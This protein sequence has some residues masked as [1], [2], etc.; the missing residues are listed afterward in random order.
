M[1]VSLSVIRAGGR[2]GGSERARNGREAPGLFIGEEMA[3]PLPSADVQCTSAA[4]KAT[5]TH[6]T[7]PRVI[8]GPG[9]RW[10]AQFDD[11]A[12]R[13]A[14]LPPCFGRT[15]VAAWA[16]RL[17][18]TAKRNVNNMA[19]CGPRAFGAVRAA[20]SRDWMPR[21]RMVPPSG[22]IGRGRTDGVLCWLFRPGSGV[23]LDWDRPTGATSRLAARAD[24]G[25]RAKPRKTNR[26]RR[27]Q[28]GLA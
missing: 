22:A 17:A 18:E 27:L 2:E 5:A 9:P 3:S 26:R 10:R 25:R 4:A 1:T 11:A 23:G 20:G 8:S 6:P 13:P 7:R 12:P 19:R 21:G 16:A 28:P 15:P 24:R 14:L